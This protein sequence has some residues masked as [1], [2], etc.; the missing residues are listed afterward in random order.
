MSRG[1]LA[2]ALVCG[3]AALAGALSVT[4]AA[5]GQPRARVAYELREIATAREPT[6]VVAPPSR[7]RALL[8]TERGGRVL[9]LRGSRRR[10]REFLDI[11]NL[12]SK[13]PEAGLL[14]IA[15][16]PDYRRSGVL[17]A[18]Y[19]NRAGSVEVDSFRATRSG[20]RARPGSRRTVIE[21][22]KPEGG[23]GHFGGT[24]EFGPDGMLYLAVGDGN[25]NG[26]DPGENA[27]D[28]DSLRGK[29]LRIHP[30]PDGGYEVPADNPYAAGGGAPEVYASGL[31]NPFRFSIEGDEIAIGDVGLASYEEVDYLP[32]S[33][34]RGANFGW[35]AFEGPERLDFDGDEEALVDDAGVYQPM[36]AYPHGPGICAV[37]GGLVVR[38]R[39]LPELRGAYLYADHCEGEL[40]AF[41]P[42]PAQ[43]RATD[44]RALGRRVRH[45]TAFGVDARGHVVIATLLGPVYRLVAR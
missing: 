15:F 36:H 37:T 38:D 23:D 2:A 11:R 5:S 22:P 33:A 6:F 14:S 3:A 18:Y 44:H 39:A 25:W 43:N 1:P 7:A 27:Q 9:A 21:I 28:L 10:P 30:L 40:R 12:V 26:A 42:H 4:P 20:R 34:A 24:A 45:P 31:R 17:Y 16:A 32:L 8:V 41:E 35:D 19:V 13:T 29:L